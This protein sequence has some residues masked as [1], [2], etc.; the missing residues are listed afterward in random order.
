MDSANGGPTA[1]QVTFPPVYPPCPLSTPPTPSYPLHTLPAAQ[2]GEGTANEG[3]EKRK[4]EE[5]GRRERKRERER[6]REGERE[7]E[8]QINQ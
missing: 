5:R 7:R 6:E 4:R 1:D 8:E 2:K 3:G